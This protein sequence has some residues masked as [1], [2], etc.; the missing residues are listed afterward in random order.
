MGVWVIFGNKAP[1][2]V[3]N[4]ALKAFQ[5]LINHNTRG[6]MA[7]DN[8]DNPVLDSGFF[9]RGNHRLGNPDKLIILI[10]N[11]AVAFMKEHTPP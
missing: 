3:V 5:S 2:S 4:V 9:Y 8:R 11:D 6:G 7:A 10:G 1:Q